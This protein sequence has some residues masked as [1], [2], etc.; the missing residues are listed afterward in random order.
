MRFFPCTVHLWK[1]K[2][3]KELA[4]LRNYKAEHIFLKFV[5]LILCFCFL[6]FVLF[7]FLLETESYCLAL[8]GL[9]L[10]T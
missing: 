10:T 2:S 1:N 6:F 3:E 4:C 8:G 5:W 9:E 7:V